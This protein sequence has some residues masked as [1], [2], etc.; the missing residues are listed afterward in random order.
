[1]KRNFEFDGF[2]VIRWGDTFIDLHNAYDLAE[3]GTNLDGSEATLAFIRNA[4][5]IARE[6][7]PP[8]VTLRCTGNVQ[9]AFNDL[10]AIA[11][12]LDEEGIERRVRFCP[13]RGGPPT[14]RRA[15]VRC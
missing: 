15:R 7:L 3:F 8:K 9:M 14:A 13:R 12:P 10:S 11:V 5:A 6:K 1:M 2:S 4:H